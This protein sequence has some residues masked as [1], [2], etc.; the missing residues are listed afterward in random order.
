M[1][2]LLQQYAKD[3]QLHLWAGSWLF[4]E[5]EY[6]LAQKRLEEAV[7]IDTD[8]APALNDLGYVYA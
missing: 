1:N 5:K 3:K 4:H 8:F 7:A 6:E 2:E